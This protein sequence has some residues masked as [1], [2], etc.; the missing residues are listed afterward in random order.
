MVAAFTVALAFG[1]M[2][3]VAYIYMLL[4]EWFIVSAFL[5]PALSYKSMLGLVV[6]KAFLGISIENEVFDG[7]ALL[8]RSGVYLTAYTFMWGLAWF[9]HQF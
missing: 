7:P 4:W 3:Y 8:H 5:V 6:I 9:V 2:F 1:S